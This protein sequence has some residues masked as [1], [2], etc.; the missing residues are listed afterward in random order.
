MKSLTIL[1]ILLLLVSCGA[2]ESTQYEQLPVDS[3]IVDPTTCV[4][5]G[6]AYGEDPVR[7]RSIDSV[8]GVDLP[9]SEERRTN[10]PFEDRRC[11]DAEAAEEQLSKTDDA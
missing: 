10:V 9:G 11:S 5:K 2:D 6:K 4:E 3:E 8:L 7:S 1:T